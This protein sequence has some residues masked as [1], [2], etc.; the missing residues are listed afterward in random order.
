MNGRTLP[1]EAA[2]LIP[3]VDEQLF[4]EAEVNLLSSGIDFSETEV[5]RNTIKFS[6]P[7]YY[8]DK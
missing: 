3:F 4:L 1:W 2:I 8:Y 7:V 6:Y 5:E